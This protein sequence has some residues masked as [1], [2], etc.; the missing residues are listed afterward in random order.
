MNKQR[1]LTELKRL[2]VFMTDSDRDLT[3]ARYSDMFDAAGDEGEE[4]VLEKLG[5]PTKLAISLSRGYEPGQVTAENKQKKALREATEAARAAKQKAHDLG[6]YSPSS[7]FEKAQSEEELDPVDMILRSLDQDFSDEEEPEKEE[8]PPE[9]EPEEEI[10]VP[11]VVYKRLHPPMPVGLGG[12][13]LGLILLVL[14]LPLAALTLALV[15]LCLTPG[16][17][18]IACAGLSA[19][20]ALWCI[21]QLAD[22]LLLF[23]LGFLFLAVGLVLL[24]LGLRLDI[25]LVKLYLLGVNALFD[26]LL[27]K[28][29]AVE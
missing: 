10:P 19:I 21:A 14:G 8:A 1:F 6:D 29:E 24:W 13:L 28:K 12:T 2:L 18:G 26:A 11:V 4:A 5:S 22:A 17:A 25:R 7:L 20:A 16:G 23:G 27:G 9:E 15:I 3:I